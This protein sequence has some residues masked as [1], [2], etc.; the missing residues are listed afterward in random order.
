[1]LKREFTHVKLI[2]RIYIFLKI[3]ETNSFILTLF[4]NNSNFIKIM[5]KI[6]IFNKKN[7]KI[8]KNNP[9]LSIIK[10]YSFFYEEIVFYFYYIF[11]R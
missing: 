7:Y 10:A 9:K 3:N 11:E 6:Q 5:K 2:L 1:M 8:I 4:S